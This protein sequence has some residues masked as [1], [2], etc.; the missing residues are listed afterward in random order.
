MATRQQGITALDLLITMALVALLAMVGIP[1][2][3]EY[4]AN[5][6]MKSA[7]TLLHSDLGLAR[8]DAIA[9]NS[10]VIACPGA[11]DSGCHN[12]ATWH[13]GWLVFADLNNDLTWQPLEPLLRHGDA[14]QGLTA[15]GPESRPL[16]RF[17]PG[18]SAPGSNTSIVF[19]DTR[20]WTRGTKLLIS[21][22]GRMRRSGL[23]STDSSRCPGS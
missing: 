14:L 4:Q 5:Q 20:G 21:N 22:S 16:V 13:R 10:H 11:P 18:G 23:A 15:R 8:S 2:L 7:V 19:C 12:D 6:V 3:R 1:G 17:F 9:L